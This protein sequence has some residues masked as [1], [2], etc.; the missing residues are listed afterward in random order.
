MILWVWI[1]GIWKSY[2]ELPADEKQN[3]PPKNDTKKLVS[4]IVYRLPHTFINK[5]IRILAQ[6]LG[7]V[8]DHVKRS[9]TDCVLNTFTNFGWKI[10]EHR[11]H[12]Q[13]AIQKFEV[14]LVAVALYP[15]N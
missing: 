13:V 2:Q 12:V 5:L 3:W 1:T 8:E 15:L 11:E 7:F 4:C 14:S 6:I 10:Q 9:R